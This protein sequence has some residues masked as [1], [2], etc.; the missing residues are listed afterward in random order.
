MHAC[1]SSKVLK[2]QYNTLAMLNHQHVYAHLGLDCL[3]NYTYTIEIPNVS[4]FL[5]NTAKWQA[6]MRPRL[7]LIPDRMCLYTPETLALSAYVERQIAPLQHT[8]LP[9]DS[10]KIHTQHAWAPSKFRHT[11]I[12]PNLLSTISTARIWHTGPTCRGVLL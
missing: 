3:T 5:P 6:L 12:R 2:Q 10:S 4:R 1:L 11:S 9:G 7:L 8:P